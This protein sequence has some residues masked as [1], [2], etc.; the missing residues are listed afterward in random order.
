MSLKNTYIFP[1]KCNPSKNRFLLDVEDDKKC[2]AGGGGGGG[3]LAGGGGD[4]S[5]E[6]AKTEVAFKL[7]PISRAVTTENRPI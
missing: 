5:D 1:L 6:A 2:G 3:G 4:A 7:F